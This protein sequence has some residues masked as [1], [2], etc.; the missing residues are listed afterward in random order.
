MS[1]SLRRRY[2]EN[3]VQA[4]H[5]A[6]CHSWWKQTKKFLSLTDS[7]SLELPN[8]ETLANAINSYF[9]SV[10]Q[11]LPPIDSKLLDLLT[12]TELT[13]DFVIE[14]YE[15]AEKLNKLNIYIKPLDRT[16][17]LHGYY[18]NVHRT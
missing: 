13:A 3:K 5:D 10:S 14:P 6:D 11:D 12:D 9:V 15:V 8:G 18:N 4:L 1:R 16:Q 2:Y 17:F 7:D